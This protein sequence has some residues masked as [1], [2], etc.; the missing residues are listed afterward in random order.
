MP[1]NY[2]FHNAEHYP[3]GINQYVPALQGL[4]DHAWDYNY[5]FDMGAPNA[6]GAG[7]SI[8]NAGA[9]GSTFTPGGTPGLA[10]P[11]ALMDGQ[12]VLDARWGREVVIVGSGAGT[13]N[14]TIN[15]YD[16]LGQRVSKT[17]ALNGATPVP[18]AI[19][20]KRIDSIVVAA[21]GAITV[22][23]GV[24]NALGLP[25]RTSTIT[26][27]LVDGTVNTPGTLTTGVLTDPAT[28]GTG[29]P[30]GLYTPTVTPDGIKQFVLVGVINPW[31]NDNGNGG[32]HGIRQFA[33]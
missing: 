31:V 8:L 32:L 25:Y 27:E 33:A 29:D 10:A 4:A 19:A 11:S 24:T 26:R 21:G 1:K 5:L 14:V 3:F 2:N 16:Y 7:N 12:G 15:G 17:K 9:V 28:A 23:V 20:L 13:N 22:N 6:A 18:M 30:R